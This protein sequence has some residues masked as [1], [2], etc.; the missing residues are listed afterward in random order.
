MDWLS[1]L[2]DM[3][4]VSGQLELRCF[5]GAPWRVAYD[6]S[7]AG[8]MPYHV[9]VGGSAVLEDPGGGPPL[10]LEAGDILLLPHG[11]AHVLHDGSGRRPA[12]AS[13]R[14][15]L[16]LI[17]SENAGRGDRLDMLCGRFTLAPPHDRLL[18]DYLPPRLVVRTAKPGTSATQPGTGAQLTSLVELMRTESGIDSLGG[19]AM[20]N[21]LSAA[22]FALTLRFA[23]ESDEAPAGLLALAGHPRLAPALSALFHEPARP[24]TLPELARLCNMSRATLARHFQERLG[25]SASDLLTDIRMTLAANEL[26]KSS[27][28]IGAVAEAVGYQS[29]A[30]FQRA[31]KQR[32]GVTP[33]RWR[34]GAHSSNEGSS[35]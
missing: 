34:R 33:A 21:A 26:R 15:N 24:W 35:F 12:K 23:S 14:A 6:L 20:L 29:E 2:L 3:M 7:E 28:A 5:Y 10:H 19:H 13:N 18:L 25:R 8:H 31:F 30:A 32:M 11:G 9:V 17:I 4:P 27:L 16:N 1:S 22:L